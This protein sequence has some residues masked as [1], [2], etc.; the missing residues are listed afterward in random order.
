ARSGLH[1]LPADPQWLKRK[2]PMLNGTPD[3]RPLLDAADVYGEPTPFVRF[4]NPPKT[5]KAA[6]A[7]PAG[8]TRSKS[9]T[10]TRV[11]TRARRARKTRVEESRIEETEEREDREETKPLRVSKEKNRR[12]KKR[13]STT[14][15]QRQ[16]RAAET[17]AEE[18]EKPE[19]PI[20]SEAGS[21]KGHCVPRPTRSAFSRSKPQGIGEIVNEWL[22]SHWQDPR[23]EQFGWE[24]VRALG[25]SHDPLNQHSR[26][27]WGA[28]AAW[29]YKVEQSA[30]AMALEEIWTV[31]IGKANYLRTKGKSAKNRSAVWFHIMAGE[32]NQRGV[33]ITPP[34]R[35]SPL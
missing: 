26:S 25:Y 8:P 7:R 6:K 14:E 4:C 28:F 3:L 15:Q 10:G 31:A 27:E 32:L 20:E 18:P 12:E 21:A 35:A 11:A 23:A 13:I 19:N 34:A 16:Q 24:I 30:P 2:I 22:P 33:S 9:K 5:K 17:A 29:W 1:I